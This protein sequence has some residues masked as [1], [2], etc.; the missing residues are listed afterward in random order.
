MQDAKTVTIGAG[1]FISDNAMSIGPEGMDFLE[2]VVPEESRDSVRDDAIAI[3]SRGTSPKASSGSQT[4]LV[5]GY[6]QSG[7]T[8]SFEAV[9]ALARDNQIQIVIVVAGTSNPLLGQSTDRLR[10]DLQLDDPSRARRWLQFTNPNDDDATRQRI[11]NVLEEWREGDTPPEGRKTVLITVLKNFRRLAYLKEL[12]AKVG[13]AGVPTL[14]IDD[15]ADQ[16]SLNNAVSKASESSTYSAVMR[17]KDILPNHTYLQYTATPQAPLLISLIDALSPTFVRVIEPGSA[18]VGGREFFENRKY[19]RVI[20]PQDVPT[21]N[22]PLSGPPDSLLQALRIFLLGVAAG[23]QE[24]GGTGNRSMLVHPSQLT[25]QHQEF[26]I[27]VRDAFE[28][29]KRVLALPEDDPDRLDLVEEFRLAYADLQETAGDAL[30]DFDQIAKTLR[31]AMRETSYEQVNATGGQTPKIAWGHTYGWILVGGQ[32]MDRGFTVE[33]L[34]VT[35]MPRGKG[36]GH[37]DTV[38]QR[39][40]FFGYKRSYLGF[41]RVYLEQGTID[42]FDA[43]VVHEEDVRLQLKEFQAGER[44]LKEWKRAFILDKRLKPCR[45]SVL[46]LPYMQG[47]FSN[48]WAA[49]SVVNVSESILAEN[50]AMIDAYVAKLAFTDMEGHADRTA[51]MRHTVSGEIPLSEALDELLSRYRVVNSLDSQEYTGLLLQIDLALEKNPDETCRIIQISP[52]A[53]PRRTRTVNED[54]EV[55]NLYQGA[56]PVSPPTQRGKVYPGDREVRF[57]DQITIQLHR[58]DLMQETDGK[59]R[60]VAVDVRVISTWVP[61]RLAEGWLVQPKG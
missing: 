24:D 42:M 39:A 12:L 34:T 16:A 1:A 55:S 58:L 27:W 53:N 48:K 31:R 21:K 43:Y 35:Y 56:A 26:F 29:W 30:G 18:Y 54:G 22:N 20:P 3:L 11:K 41:C 49:P 7:K 19:I 57:D 8:M 5:I 50:R 23:L 51:A 47:E 38:Q 4:G 25:V 46:A 9:T 44:S 45:Q 33:G 15:E 6:V 13:M 40:R 10:R 36:V 52:D 60:I 32:A 14:I 61:A 2:R 59:N 28:G 37:A 17:L